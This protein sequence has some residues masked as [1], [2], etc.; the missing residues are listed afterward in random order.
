MDT[1]LLGKP[2]DFSGKIDDWHD[3]SVI[4]E[5]CA[6]A[7][8]PGLEAGMSRA[9]EASAIVLFNATLEAPTVRV[10]QQLYWMLLMLCKNTALQIVVGAGRGEGLEAWKLLR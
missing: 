3:W 10:S 7:A 9:V 6:A 4:F 1:R 2:R 5:G 8:V